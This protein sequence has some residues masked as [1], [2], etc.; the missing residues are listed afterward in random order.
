MNHIRY[1]I[2]FLVIYLFFLPLSYGQQ[3][4]DS[5]SQKQKDIPS[6]YVGNST[7]SIK[8]RSGEYKL[9]SVTSGASRELELPIEIGHVADFRFA[10]DKVV[11]V[12]VMNSSMA[13]SIV[14]VDSLG[15]KILDE[16]W[17]YDPVFSPNEA[18]IAFI[19]FFPSHFVSSPESQYHLYDLRLTAHLNRESESRSTNIGAKLSKID[20]GSII[21]P[22]NKSEATRP[23]VEVDPKLA[24][25]SRS[26]FSWSS[27]SRSLAF[28]DEQN[29][30]LRLV[31]V[32]LGERGVNQSV[33]YDIPR[34]KGQCLAPATTVRC[35]DLASIELIVRFDQDTGK[36]YV[37]ARRNTF[38]RV[39]YRAGP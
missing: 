10:A 35:D 17:C 11:V 20:V 28:V 13:M 31:V 9:L 22:E 32:D 5:Q 16:F 38:E 26:A 15:E 1:A 29:R 7:Y 30:Q 25:T 6:L 36:P 39:V 12:G 23:N 14:V 27:E 33:E 2:R 34:P 19:K 18:Q 3:Y 8:G 21:W 37:V 4:H 24:H